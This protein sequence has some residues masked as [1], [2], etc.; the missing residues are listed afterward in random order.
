[1]PYLQYLTGLFLGFSGQNFLGK[2]IFTSD[3][4]TGGFAKEKTGLFG[5]VWIEDLR[6]PCGT[7]G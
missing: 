4:E 6:P 2:S 5:A 7:G 1:L 3:E